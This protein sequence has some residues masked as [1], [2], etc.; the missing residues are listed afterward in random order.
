EQS[1]TGHQPNITRLSARSCGSPACAG[2]RVRLTGDGILR[3]LTASV[4]SGGVED[5]AAS[6]AAEAAGAGLGDQRVRLA[7]L[8]LLHLCPQADRLQRRGAVRD[9]A[10]AGA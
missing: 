2:N 4:R 6:D 9:L 1:A 7:D 10:D 8:R 5:Q 3:T